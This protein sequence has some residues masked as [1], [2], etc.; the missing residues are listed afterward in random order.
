MSEFGDGE[1]AAQ[2][3]AFVSLF[4]EA[5]RLYAMV[6][7]RAFVVAARRLDARN[8]AVH[9]AVIASFRLD[10]W[11]SGHI[12]VVVY[13]DDG[14]EVR[15]GFRVSY[16]EIDGVTDAEIEAC[17][18]K[19]AQRRY[20]RDIATYVRIMAAEDDLVYLREER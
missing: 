4:A 9:R 16:R 20:E 3:A 8:E 13:R 6:V 2:P 18:A 17:A 1:S 14:S 5:H 10:S 7:Q 19:L 12:V 11:D 15:Y